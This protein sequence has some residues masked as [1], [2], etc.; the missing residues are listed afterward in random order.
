MNKNHSGQFHEKTTYFK[1]SDGLKEFPP[2]IY[3]YSESLIQLDLSGNHLSTLPDDFW[4]FENLRILFLS[5]NDF[6]SFP[7]VLGEMKNLDIIGFKANRIREIP[8]ATFPENL[9]WLILTD[10]EIEELPI[11]IGNCSRLQKLMLAGNR[12]SK[13]PGE[14][15]K[16]KNLELIRVSA[17]RLKAIPEWLFSLP[18]LT[19]L[20]YAG[21]PVSTIFA[22]PLLTSLDWNLL[23]LAEQLGQ[24]AS[25]FIY[26]A[27]WNGKNVAVKLFKGDVTS[28]GWPSDELHASIRAEQHPSIIPVLA[29]IQNHPEGKKGLVFELISPD[30]QNLGLPPN[31]ETCTRDTIPQN[32]NFT[33]SRIAEVAYLMASALKHLHDRGI[34]HGDFYAHNILFN[35]DKNA[36]LS[37]FGAATIYD[38]KESQL[39]L[40]LERLDV[41]AFGCLLDDL[42]QRA[43][44]ESHR[45]YSYLCDLRNLC[46]NDDPVERPALASIV[47]SL[48]QL[49]N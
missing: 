42:L 36:L 43:I 19:W 35:S 48:L 45:F 32:S 8:E 16:C 29:E 27:S 33:C 15:A 12:L 24:G 34:M 31:F 47:S 41:R 40:K 1:L 49:K 38:R 13:L 28:D 17:N 3:E 21:N 37:D 7:K 18:K 39:S 9:R 22:Q 26:K 23:T 44:D 4:K 20:A 25:G 2:N 5:N 14:M 6:T 46:L 30:F 11:S 10:N